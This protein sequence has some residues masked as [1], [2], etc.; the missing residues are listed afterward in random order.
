MS[1]LLF[2]LSFPHSPADKLLPQDISSI[3]EVK[4]KIKQG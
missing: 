2:L 4:N 3:T 1:S